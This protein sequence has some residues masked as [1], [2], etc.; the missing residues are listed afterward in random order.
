MGLIPC[1]QNLPQNQCIFVRGFRVTRILNIWHRL[2]GAGP[3]PD[4][5]EREPESDR[6][7]ELIS[8]PADTDVCSHFHHFLTFAD[9]SKYKDP[10]HILSAHIAEVSM[11]VVTA[12]AYLG[13]IETSQQAPDCN[14]ILVHDDDLQFIDDAVSLFTHSSLYHRC[15]HP[16]GCWL[17]CRQTTRN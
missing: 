7:L 14:M 4:F 3:V 9:V 2:H 8:I 12:R 5:G 15:P 13:L 6:R 11:I 1:V 16:C 17:P 10:L